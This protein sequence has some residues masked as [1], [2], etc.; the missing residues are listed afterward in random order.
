MQPA[1]GA[2]VSS[3]RSGGEEAPAQVE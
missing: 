1:Q 3:R 2:C